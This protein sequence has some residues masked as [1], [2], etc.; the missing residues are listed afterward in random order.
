MKI[1]FVNGR[2]AVIV[3]YW[4]QHGPVVDGGARVELRRVDQ[5]EGENHR[6]GAAG[7]A[8][9]PI[10]EGGLW[11]ADL[12]MILSEPGTSCFHYHPQFEN[13]DVGERFEDA[14]LTADPRAWVERQLGDLEG[15]LK[16]C[17]ASDLLPSIDLDEHRRALP[18]MLTAVDACLARVPVAM[19][20]L[21]TRVSA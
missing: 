13:G 3:R 14:D 18:M 9:R 21:P 5:L 20:S 16:R 6:E 8:V 19:A 7:L 2:L 12:F 1:V 4:E 17:G 15:L 11:R 10:S